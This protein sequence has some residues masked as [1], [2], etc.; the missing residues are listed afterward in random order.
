MKSNSSDDSAIH[1]TPS[2]SGFNIRI[3]QTYFSF[4]TMIGK[5]FILGVNYM[6]VIQ[7]SAVALVFGSVF[8][9]LIFPK[10]L[11]FGMKQASAHQMPQHIF[12][13][14]NILPRFLSATAIEAWHKDA[15]NVCH[16]PVSPGL[17]G[18]RVQHYQSRRGEDGR[19]ADCERTRP[20]LF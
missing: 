13:R 12:T 2:H 10:I 19:K 14:E 6:K 5:H 8:G 17:Q 7:L 18:P 20:V 4:A 9:F 1:R 15:G 11:K 16:H 3:V